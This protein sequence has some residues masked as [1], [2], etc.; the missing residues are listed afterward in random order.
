M[1]Q[2]TVTPPDSSGERLLDDIMENSVSHIVVRGR[3]WSVRWKRRRSLRWVSKILLKGKDED[4]VICQCAAALRLDSLVKLRLFHWLLWRWYYYVRSYQPGELLPYIAECKKKVP[5]ASYFACI[6]L[7]TGM[8]DT[9]M[10][11][12]REEAGRIRLAQVMGQ[13]GPSEKSTP[14]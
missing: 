14:S 12:S 13:H 10:M 1:K 4:K 7:L 5:L 8:R 6:T 9:E 11:M 3:K 2:P